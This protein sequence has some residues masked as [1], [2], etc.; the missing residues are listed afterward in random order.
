MRAERS[1][2]V[3]PLNCIR[4]VWLQ[5]DVTMAF[6]G[7]ALLRCNSFLFFLPRGKPMAFNW[8]PTTAPVQTRYDDIWFI[9]LQVGWA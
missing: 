5:V 2:L 3:A 4:I 8:H 9:S 6:R 1:D 7:A